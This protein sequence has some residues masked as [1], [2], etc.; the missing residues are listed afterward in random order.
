MN[1]EWTLAQFSLGVAIA[2]LAVAVADV[3]VVSVVNRFRAH[4]YEQASFST[5]SP[6]ALLIYS[7]VNAPASASHPYPQSIHL[8]S[9][10]RPPD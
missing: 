7:I 6:H 5:F 10:V 1:P 4:H 9:T 3:A 2:C 8:F